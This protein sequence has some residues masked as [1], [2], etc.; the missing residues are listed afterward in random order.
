MSTS[1][2]WHNSQCTPGPLLQG[3]VCVLSLP[4]CGHVVDV[5]HIPEIW[6]LGKGPGDAS[7]CLQGPGD[8][9]HCHCLAKETVA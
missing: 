3:V 5:Y 1:A 7:H 2:T 4:Q 9:S 8:A 6:L